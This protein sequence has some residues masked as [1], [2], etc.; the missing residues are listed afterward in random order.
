MMQLIS[1]TDYR[2][3][4][5][6]IVQQHLQRNYLDALTRYS[7]LGEGANQFLRLIHSPN[8]TSYNRGLRLL[9]EILP[10]IR[11]IIL[12]N[13]LQV[14]DFGVGDGM[15]SLRILS[16][17]NQECN[18]SYLG[19]DI[20]REMLEIARNN[21]LNLPIDITTNYIQ[22]NFNNLRQL[23]EILNRISCNT[24]LF[25]LLGNTLTNEV[26]IESYLRSLRNVLNTTNQRN[27]LL[28]GL[29]PFQDDINQIVREYRNEE[30]YALTI[31][32]LEII[33]ITTNDGNVDINFNY[34]QQRIEEWFTF[35]RNMEVV[36]ES[37]N[38]R[39][40]E[41]DRILLS[42]TYNP[43]LTQIREIIR[44]SGWN[45]EIIL[46]NENRDYLMILLSS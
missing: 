24:R 18:L 6:N 32:P 41:G 25:L 23:T 16:Y 33:G 1:C 5:A 43:T 35:T 14:I 15:L 44:N 28:I 29:E 7:Y 31:R 38:I 40:H 37:E 21:Q 9:N 22:C 4:I 39:F 17:L 11:N 26:N 12:S 8:Y 30:N 3:E 13:N 19:L 27:Y 46:V 10:R 2:R 34:E 45:E 42:V 20:S 36:I